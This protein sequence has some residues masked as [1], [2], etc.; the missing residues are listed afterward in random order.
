[1]VIPLSS[2]KCIFVLHNDREIFAEKFMKHVDIILRMLQKNAK[3]MATKA[4]L[5]CRCRA[6]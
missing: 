5:N 2:A 6:T 1:M 4:K 3:I